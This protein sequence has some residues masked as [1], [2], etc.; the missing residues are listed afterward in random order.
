MILVCYR[1]GAYGFHIGD[2]V[3]VPDDTDR[4]DGYTFRKKEAD[5]PV[6]TTTAENAG[7]EAS[8]E[9]PTVEGA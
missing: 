9:A 6:T 1:E 7:T 3:E 2:E 4:W 8:G 5:P